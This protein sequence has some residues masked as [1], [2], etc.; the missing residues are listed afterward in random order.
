MSERDEQR[1][2][3]EK[4]VEECYALREE[5]AALREKVKEAEN[6]RQR[7]IESIW[8]FLRTSAYTDDMKRL[9]RMFEEMYIPHLYAPKG[10]YEP[11]DKKA[12]GER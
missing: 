10:W 8:Q 9:V 11:N 1:Y 4:R 6:Y 2:F 5:V 7:V 12:E 3:I